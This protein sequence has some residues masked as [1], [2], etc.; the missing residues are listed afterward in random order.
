MKRRSLLLYTLCASSIFSSMYL[1]A[2]AYT[3]GSGKNTKEYRTSY[4]Q[5][6]HYEILKKP[7]H[8]GNNHVTLVFWFGSPNSFSVYGKLKKFALENPQVEV[9]YLPSTLN[10]EWIDGARAYYSLSVMGL[11]EEQR[12]P[13]FQ[14][15]NAGVIRDRV[16]MERYLDKVG[17][18][19]DRFWEIFFSAQSNKAINSYADLSRSAELEYVPTVVVSG[20][21][22]VIPTTMAKWEES[23]SLI[24][25]LVDNQPRRAFKQ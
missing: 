10:S 7:I 12:E 14:A 6:V 13:F 9:S 17:I 8:S 19:V 3:V 21:Y 25:H 24:K 16:S 5:G 18:D 1:G 11:I 22:K 20:K 4:H 2:F 23:F 15:Y